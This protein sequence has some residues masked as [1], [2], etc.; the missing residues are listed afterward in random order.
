MSFE[1]DQKEKQPRASRGDSTVAGVVHQQTHDAPRKTEHL[2]KMMGAEVW[3]PP[4]AYYGDAITPMLFGIAYRMLGSVMEAEDMVQETY[5]RFQA[6][7]P[8]SIR[9]PLRAGPG[10]G[11]SRRRRCLSIRALAFVADITS[12]SKPSVARLRA[13]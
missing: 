13:R 2:D 10:T 12:M 7:P 4:A 11:F 9:A 8:E 5:L 1:H 6:T 3:P